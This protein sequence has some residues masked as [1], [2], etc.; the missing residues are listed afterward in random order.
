MGNLITQDE[1]VNRASCQHLEFPGE[2]AVMQK[3]SLCLVAL[4]F[5]AKGILAH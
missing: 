3:P 4:R 5:G 1:I 2:E